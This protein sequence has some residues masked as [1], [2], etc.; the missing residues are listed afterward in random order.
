VVEFSVVPSGPCGKL[1]TGFRVFIGSV[2]TFPPGSVV[3]VPAKLLHAGGV[4]FDLA[5]PPKH[6]SFPAF[7]PYPAGAAKL[8]RFFHGFEKRGSTIADAARGR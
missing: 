1:S 5:G 4:F 3:D 2:L 7:W 8:A 6:F